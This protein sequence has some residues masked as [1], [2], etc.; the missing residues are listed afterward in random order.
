MASRAGAT[1]T[2]AAGSRVSMVSH[3]DVTIGAILAAA[4]TV[5]D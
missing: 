3:P 2:D 4:A 5:G 1:T